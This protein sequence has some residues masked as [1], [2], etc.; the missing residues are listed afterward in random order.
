MNRQGTE[1]VLLFANS[2]PLAGRWEINAPAE[3]D[4]EWE[5][6]ATGRE[7]TIRQGRTLLELPR[8]GYALFRRKASGHPASR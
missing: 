2:G 6:I 4:G 3:F 7:I 1:A 5:D 8:W